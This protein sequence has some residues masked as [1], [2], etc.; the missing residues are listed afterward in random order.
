MKV[1][2]V[3]VLYQQRLHDCVSYNSLLK[4]VIC[5]EVQLFI[6]DNSKRA[7]HLQSEF[8]TALIHYISDTTNSGVSVGYNKAAIYARENGFEKL[9]LLDQDSYFESFSYVDNCIRLSTIYPAI[10]LFAPKV[11]TKQKLPMSP[12]RLVCKIPVRKSFIPDCI[13]PLSCMGIINSGI[14]V[15]VNAFFQVGGYNEKVFLDYSDYQ[16]IDRFCVLYNEFYLVN[17]VIIQDFSNSQTDKSLLLH[18]FKL[19]QRSLSRYECNNMIDKL[20][21][22][23]IVLKRCLSLTWRCKSMH[24]VK[25]LLG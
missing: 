22:K 25:S 14:F 20:S 18:R 9:L 21:L 19:F 23:L 17:N 24:F 11:M 1:L 8:N 4:H 5:N 7:M 6:Y 10:K 16:F 2:C 13:Y 12:R 15:D 3:V